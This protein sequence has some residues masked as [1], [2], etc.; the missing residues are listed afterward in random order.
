MVSDRT[1]DL[2]GPRRSVGPR[3]LVVA[4]RIAWTVVS[5]AVVQA[6]VCLLA[7]L[8]VVVIWSRLL[9][10]LPPDG[11]I[12]LFAISGAVIPSYLLFSLVLMPVSAFVMRLTGWRTMPGVEMRIADMDWRL[13]DWARAM[14]GTHLVRFF[15]GALFRGTPIWTAYLRMAGARM[16]RRVY[17]N[18]LGVSDYNLL[19][20]GDGVVIGADVHLSGHTVEK[21][22]VKTAPVTLGRNVTIGLCSIIDIGVEIGDDAQVGAMSLVPK[23]TRLESGFVYAGVPAKLLETP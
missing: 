8:P 7:V 15:S 10:M 23:H 19:E 20:F 17:V 12:R 18:S 14:I 4:T 13:L 6:I 22:V 5:A 1:V 16:G 11:A 3:G 21:G 9:A 2:Q